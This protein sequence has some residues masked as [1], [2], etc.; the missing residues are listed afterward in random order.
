MLSLALTN[1]PCLRFILSAFHYMQFEIKIV[2]KSRLGLGFMGSRLA[3]PKSLSI[4]SASLSKDASPLGGA[5]ICN[6]TGNPFFVNPH[7]NDR[8]GREVIVIA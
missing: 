7:G 4:F 1:I 5:T 2:Y 6:P 8:A 3:M